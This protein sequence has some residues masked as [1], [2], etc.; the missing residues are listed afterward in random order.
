MIFGS[1]RENMNR[2]H[3][4]INRLKQAAFLLGCFFIFACENDPKVIEELSSNKLMV[5]E[6]VDIETFLSQGNRMKAKLWAPYM[7][8][9]QT[10]T[11]FVE[12]PRSLHVNFFDSAGKVE[13]HL[14][15][16]YGRYLENY[17]KVF[18]RDSVVVFNVQGDTLHCHDLIW[19]QNAQNF[20]TDNAVRVRK[21]G[22]LI[23]GIG[24]T[25]KQDLSNINIR[26]VTGT[27]M[28]H[29]SLMAE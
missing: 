1:V 12:F 20:T 15:A 2:S 28:V 9:Y 22:H 17:N 7:L 18:L 13:S 5:E 27:L 23:F 29:D 16:K 11:V 6:A 25:A 8:R 19:D 10:D 21:G 4:Y 26:R 3:G 14:D 24:L